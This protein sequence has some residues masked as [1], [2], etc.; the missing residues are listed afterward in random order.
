MAEESFQEKT[1]QATSK[2]REKSRE[3]GQVSRSPEIASVAVL[4]A[5]VL[6]LYAFAYFFYGQLLEVLRQDFVFN[7]VPDLTQ[8]KCIRMLLV[9]SRWFFILLLPVMAGVMAAAVAANLF[10]VGFVISGKALAFKWDRFDVFKG[11]GRLLSLRSLEELFKSG[12]KLGV[13]GI[14]AF[15]VVRSEMQETIRVYDTDTAGILV[16]ILTVIFKIF[17]WVL[18]V[19]VAV[20]ILDYGYQRWH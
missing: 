20:A 17:I 7:A 11:M 8:A 4:L 1:E 9:F 10:Q 5:G 16:F 13:I 2:K 3:E 12:I 18:I 14:V 6:I 15:L 19:M